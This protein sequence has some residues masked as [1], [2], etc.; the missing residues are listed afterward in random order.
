[1]FGQV[2]ARF[3]RRHELRRLWS[4]VSRACMASLGLAHHHHSRA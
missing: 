1:L 2:M 4:T 3:H